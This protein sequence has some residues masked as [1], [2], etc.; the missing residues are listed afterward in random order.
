LS[1]LSVLKDLEL[2]YERGIYPQTTYIFKHA[3][4]REVIYTSILSRRKKRLHEEIANA[5]E[6]IYKENLDEHYGVL[7]AHYI[8]SENYEKGADYSIKAGNRAATVFA[9]H[10]ARNHY[11]NALEILEE[12]DLEKR[13]EVFKK[14][15][16]TTWSVMDIDDSLNYAESAL[17]LYEKLGDKH[18]ELSVHMHISMAYVGGYWDGA[19]EDKALKHLEKAYVPPISASRA[20]CHHPCLGAE[21]RR[22]LRQSWCAHGYIFGHGFDIYRTDRGGS[23]L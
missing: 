17:E 1:H 18:N 19:K 5:T 14:L 12:K 22:R 8:G 9:W 15:A 21:G 2:V 13:A 23:S 10:A 20:A 7:A 16:K 6:E 4:T 11:E 3:L